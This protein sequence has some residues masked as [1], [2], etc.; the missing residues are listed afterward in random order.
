MTINLE[1]DWEAIFPSPKDNENVLL[2][3]I[4]AIPDNKDAEIYRI[5]TGTVESKW[6]RVVIYGVNAPPFTVTPK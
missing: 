2:K 5:W 3:A 6:E 1:K 4:Y